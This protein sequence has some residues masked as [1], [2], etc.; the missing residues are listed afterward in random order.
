MDSGDY[1]LDEALVINATACERCSNVLD[2]KY[3]GKEYGYEEYSEEWQKCGTV[4]QFCK[5]E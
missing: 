2:R 5:D 3:L 4:C 1:E